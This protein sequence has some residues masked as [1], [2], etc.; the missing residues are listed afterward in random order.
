MIKERLK[1]LKKKLDIDKEQREHY[2]ENYENEEKEDGDQ[3][4]DQCDQVLNLRYFG[5]NSYLL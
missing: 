5:I 4:I 2:E 3:T 1:L